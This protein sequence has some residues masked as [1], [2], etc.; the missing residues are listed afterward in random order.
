ML[1]HST[2]QRPEYEELVLDKGLRCTTGLWHRSRKDAPHTHTV[3]IHEGNEEQ[4]ETTVDPMY[5]IET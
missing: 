4:V 1:V 5:M 2:M 3:Y